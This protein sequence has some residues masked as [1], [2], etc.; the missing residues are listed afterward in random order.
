MHGNNSSVINMIVTIGAGQAD[1]VKL[2]SSGRKK[3]FSY[4]NAT[5]ALA[6]DAEKK[7]QGMK[8]WLETTQGLQSTY[9]QRLNLPREQGLKNMKL[10]ERK[11]AGKS[12]VTKHEIKRRE[13]ITLK[14][15]SR[16][17]QE[18]CKKDGVKEDIRKVARR[19]VDHRRARCSDQRKWELWAI[20]I[21]YR[22]TIDRCNKS[23]KLRPS[24]GCCIKVTL[25]I[26]LLLNLG[27]WKIEDYCLRCA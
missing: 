18:Y 9:Y 24:K 7:H 26:R 19:V 10:D 22:C 5:K 13:E 8:A 16:L 11:K 25:S 23:Q 2:H 27:L 4:F 1:P 14:T 17:T 20:G 12:R 6:T 21:R 15:I 3:I